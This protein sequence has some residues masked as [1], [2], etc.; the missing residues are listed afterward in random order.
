MVR[1]P[2]TKHEERFEVMKK[3]YLMALMAVALGGVA[4]GQDT[5]W[6]DNTT[7]SGDMRGR[8]EYI[9]EEGKDARERAR[10]R[11]RLLAEAR[12]TGEFRVG[13]GLATT[14]GGDPV[15]SNQTLDGGGSRKD[16]YFDLGYIVYGPSGTGFKA[17]LGKMKQPFYG[18]RDMIF[19]NDLNPEGLALSYATKEDAFDFSAVGGAMVIDEVSAG[20]DVYMYGGQ[21]ALTL[22]GE[23]ASL[24]VGASDY[25]YDDLEGH[26]VVDYV[27][28]DPTKIGS[29]GN[30][31]TKTEK[32]NADGT[33][34][35]TG[36]FY[37]Y[38]FNIV[39]GF[40]ALDLKTKVPVQVYGS[41][42]V[43][44]EADD[45][46]TAYLAGVR[47]GKTKDP[48]SWE[49]DYNY[50]E[51]EANS[52]LG[53]S[54]DSDFGGGGTDHEG[55]RIA[56]GYQVDK[57]VKAVVTYF[58]NDRNVSKGETD[59]DRLQIDLNVAF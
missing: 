13:I 3:I 37:K 45:L 9:D 22:K 50:R 20:D 19:D 30:Q 56:A 31:T 25:Y 44:T 35:V 51:L 42:A 32:E 6:Y 36:V 48:G 52:V 23:M 28:A 26:A 54:A 2:K 14:E 39:E 24:T 10:I 55:H 21:I 4:R 16:A 15:S 1:L 12:V 29:R 46:D 38:G 58:M 11:A 43:N 27:T 41:Y 47:F 59:Y 7:V 17:T 57:N 49:L 5:K 8:L 40:A 34:T 18:V 33:K 53:A